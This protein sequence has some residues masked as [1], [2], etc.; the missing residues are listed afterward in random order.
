ML[1]KVI[2][3]FKT[4]INVFRALMTIFKTLVAKL[5]AI[6]EKFSSAPDKVSKELT[7]ASKFKEP[8]CDNPDNCEYCKKKWILLH[9]IHALEYFIIGIIFNYAPQYIG[10]QENWI[11]NK[12]DT[13]G[14]VSLIFFAVGVYELY[15][16]YPRLFTYMNAYLLFLSVGITLYYAAMTT[17]PGISPKVSESFREMTRVMSFGFLILTIMSIALISPRLID[18]WEENKKNI[19]SLSKLK[20]ISGLILGILAIGTALFQFLQVLLSLFNH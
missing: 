19:K 8:H 10:T 7:E 1:K 4:L 9:T 18:W 13:G 5:S 20:K 11:I 16:A 3:V 12:G 14:Y 15:C 17:K 2:Q 6:E